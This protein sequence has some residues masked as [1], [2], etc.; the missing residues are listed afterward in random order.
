MGAEKIAAD[1]A[2][3]S[4]LIS[5]AAS[6]SPV[7]SNGVN[8]VATTFP[9]ERIERSIFLIRGQKIMIDADLAELYEIPVKVLNQ[10]VVG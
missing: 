9:T 7:L 6:I 2:R 10:A 5:S 3:E 4:L 8:P 1:A